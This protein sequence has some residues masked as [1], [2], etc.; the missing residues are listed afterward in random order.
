M[1][2]NVDDQQVP[3]WSTIARAL[4]G[5][6]DPCHCCGIENSLTYHR[7]GLARN[8]K[9]HRDWKVTAFSAAVSAATI[10]T[11]GAGVLYGPAAK[12]TAEVVYMRLVLCDDCV[13]ARRGFF[14]GFKVNPKHGSLHPMWAQ[15][16]EAGFVQFIDV[17]GDPST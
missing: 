6:G 14:G 2:S 8:V 13:D 4:E 5:E 1:E 10:S 3:E 12:K 7:F 15:V 16:C 11:L 9:T 17:D